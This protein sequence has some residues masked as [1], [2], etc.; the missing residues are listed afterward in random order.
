MIAPTVFFLADGDF[1]IGTAHARAKPPLAAIDLTDEAAVRAAFAVW[2]PE[3]VV[4]AAAERRPDVVEGDPAA[5]GQKAEY[6]GKSYFFCADDCRRTGAALR[7]FTRRCPTSRSSSSKWR[8][9]T[10]SA[11]RCS[12]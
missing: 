6:R 10:A 5:A 11:T 8:S 3:L 12:R 9:R 1:L 7:T 4:H 2:A